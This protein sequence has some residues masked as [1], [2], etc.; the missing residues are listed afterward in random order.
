MG[1]QLVMAY[2]STGLLGDLYRA[3]VYSD[4]KTLHS[5]RLLYSLLGKEKIFIRRLDVGRHATQKALYRHILATID[6]LLLALKSL[7]DVINKQDGADIKQFL[8]YRNAAAQDLQKLLHHRD[9]Q[10]RRSY[11]GG[12]QAGLNYLGHHVGLDLAYGYLTI[13]LIADA[14][15]QLVI[16]EEQATGYLG[17]GLR[18]LQ[19]SAER[20]G[21]I[22]AV[23]SV[24]D[25][26][27][28]NTVRQ[29]M[30]LIYQQGVY[31]GQFMKTRNRQ[32]LARYS[33]LRNQ[34]W[35]RVQLFA[36]P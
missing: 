28:V 30:Q 3:K 19:S 7:Q 9:L 11:R 31:L 2:Y 18:L 29:G 33:Q 24:R 25:K 4:A 14:Y 8:T 36:A 1:N 5:V 26:A 32:Y 34:A 13:G 17:P 20:L 35:Q 23:L 6:L 15:F 10:R 16:D 12:W 27:Y 21:Q 22:S